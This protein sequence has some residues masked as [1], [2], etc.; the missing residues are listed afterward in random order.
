L[1][2]RLVSPSV[3]RVY[4]QTRAREVRRDKQ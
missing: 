3:P 2:R 4:V 1:S